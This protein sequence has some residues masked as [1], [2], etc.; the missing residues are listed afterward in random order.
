M[1][2]NPK[3]QLFNKYKRDARRRDIEFKLSLAHF[4]RL[5][6]FLCY[7]CDSPPK[8]VF[9]DKRRKGFY[10]YNGIDRLNNDKGYVARNCVSCCKRCNYAKNKLTKEEF[11]SMI[12]EIYNKHLS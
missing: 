1:S 3:S 9:R 8:T 6:R 4:S 5:T 2:Y 12:E 11:L 7:Y 10:L